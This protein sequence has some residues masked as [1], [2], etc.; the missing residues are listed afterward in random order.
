MESD[1]SAGVDLVDGFLFHD[2]FV[3]IRADDRACISSL[4]RN[5]RQEEHS[6]YI[7]STVIIN[8]WSET[9]TLSFCSAFRSGR[10]DRVLSLIISTLLVA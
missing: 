6:C 2:N 8:V 3:E 5:R 9:S 10:A 4:R 7:M 1:R